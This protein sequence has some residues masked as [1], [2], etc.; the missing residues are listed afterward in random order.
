MNSNNVF[1]ILTVALAVI[2]LAGNF[3]AVGVVLYVKAQIAPMMVKLESH[4]SELTTIKTN[5]REDINTIWKEIGTV[6]ERTATIEARNK[7]IE[8][9]N[10]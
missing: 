1:Q 3:I 10:A 6:R 4:A 2:S 8:K 5:H 7:Q 9:A